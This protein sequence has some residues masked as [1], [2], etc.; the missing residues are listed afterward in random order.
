MCP[1]SSRR[2]VLMLALAA[3]PLAAF[4]QTQVDHPVPYV[5]GGVGLDE[6][7]ALLQEAKQEGY[8][9]KVVAAVSGGAYLADVRVS[10]ADGQGK[11]VLEAAMDGPWL[12]A[13]L[14]PGRYTVTASDG[15]QS[16]KR[17]VNV[18]AIGTREVI[19]RWTRGPE[20]DLPREPQS[21]P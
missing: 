4:G 5:S 17:T 18:P 11:Q 12:F 1:Q 15:Q 14:A 16:Q 10:I 13:K 9:L 3:L 21:Q 19:F 8:N 20:A 2:F 6:R 7:E